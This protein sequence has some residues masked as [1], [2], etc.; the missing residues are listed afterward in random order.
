MEVGGG[1][2]KGSSV[3]MLRVLPLYEQMGI[4]SYFPLAWYRS[5]TKKEK[6]EWVYGYTYFFY[7]ESPN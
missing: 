4:R 3:E 5:E 2:D 6:C 1:D 7:K